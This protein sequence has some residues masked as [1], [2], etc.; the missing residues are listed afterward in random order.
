MVIEDNFIEILPGDLIDPV[1]KLTLRT[2]G[3]KEAYAFDETDLNLSYDPEIRADRLTSMPSPEEQERLRKHPLLIKS[4]DRPGIFISKKRTLLVK[5]YLEWQ[6]PKDI[7]IIKLK[8]YIEYMSI[9]KKDV[10]VE[11]P[12]FYESDRKAILL[13][14]I[15]SL[16][17]MHSIRGYDLKKPTLTWS[18]L[19][20]AYLLRWP[21]VSS[22]T[23]QKNW[24][25]SSP[26]GFAL[27]LGGLFNSSGDTILNRSRFNVMVRKLSQNSPLCKV[28]TSPI[29]IV[30]P[31]FCLF[32]IQLVLCPRNSE[33]SVSPEFSDK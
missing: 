17:K 2:A 8:N 1:L 12:K 19:M 30:S 31:E 9:I 24:M 10:N 18:E 6:Q 26:A 33:F 13:Y 20:C 4:A 11:F 3:H 5:Y 16:V 22:I 7:L 27:L 32:H 21:A 29:S 28:S 15:R 25:R 14:G 23:P